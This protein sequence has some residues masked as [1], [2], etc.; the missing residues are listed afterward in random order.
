MVDVVAIESEHQSVNENLD[1]VIENYQNS[2]GSNSFSIVSLNGVPKFL[3]SNWLSLIAGATVFMEVYG[4]LKG[5]PMLNL[6]A[7]NP[8]ELLSQKIMSFGRVPQLSPSNPVSLGA[9]PQ[10]INMPTVSF[11]NVPKDLEQV[12]SQ[13]VNGIL[14]FMALERIVK[15]LR[16][17]FRK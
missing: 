7:L 11:I 14:S 8:F 2:S 13:T 3:V 10:I 9:T 1:S 6:I 15:G 12:G 17:I 16:F 5:I 4:Q